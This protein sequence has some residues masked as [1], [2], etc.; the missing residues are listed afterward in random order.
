M[1]NYSLCELLV[2]DTDKEHGFNDGI[3]GFYGK[4]AEIPIHFKNKNMNILYDYLI[5]SEY[6][7]KEIK[8]EIKK[9]KENNS[10]YTS[11]QGCLQFV[12]SEDH[13][14]PSDYILVISREKYSL[15][16]DNQVKKEISNLIDQINK[17]FNENK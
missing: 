13:N 7:S 9:I 1:G 17:F 11:K 5:N 16:K 4:K 8:S 2:N 3:F 15:D 12:L 14:H 10:N 6:V